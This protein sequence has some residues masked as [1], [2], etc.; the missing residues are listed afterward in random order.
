MNNQPIAIAGRR[1]EGRRMG[2][3]SRASRLKVRK[4]VK[5]LIYF[6]ENN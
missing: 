1:Q 4:N 5:I 6:L 2:H 3:T